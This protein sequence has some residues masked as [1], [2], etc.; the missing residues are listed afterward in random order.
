MIAHPPENSGNA[1]AFAKVVLAIADEVEAAEASLKRQILAAAENGDCA[2][3]IS[4]LNRWLETPPTE[5]LSGLATC[6]PP[7]VSQGEHP[8]AG[9][10]STQ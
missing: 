7:E 4:I 6:S 8:G 2:R 1:R 5:V 9:G 10:G 3:I